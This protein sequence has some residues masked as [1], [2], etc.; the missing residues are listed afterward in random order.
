M[1]PRQI[2]CLLSYLFV[3]PACIFVSIDTYEQ[4]IGFYRGMYEK[5][6]YIGVCMTNIV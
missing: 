5:Y 1:T 2:V 6:S 4:R 3:S